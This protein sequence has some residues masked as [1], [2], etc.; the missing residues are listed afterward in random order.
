VYE[1]VLARA[2]GLSPADQARYP[3]DTYTNNLAMLLALRRPAEA[4]RAI[5][6]MTAVIDVRGPRPA[7][8]DTRAVAYL[9]KG[10]R[11]AAAVDDLKLAL[12][13]QHAAAYLFHLG[14]A[15]DQDPAN[16]TLREAPL[17]EARRLGLTAADLH[18]L[19]ARKFNELSLP[20]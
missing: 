1:T 6:M 11:T 8:L 13:Q 10:G 3:V 16:R 19:E 2:K 5:A 4:D 12:V 18:P 20:R 17:A 9:V 7:Y 14:W 15:Y